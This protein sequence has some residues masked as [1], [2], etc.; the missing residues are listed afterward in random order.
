MNNILE[1]D[2][3]YKAV[4]SYDSEIELF[5]GEFIGLNGGA[6]FYAPDV[7]GLKKEG[8]ISIKVF[9]DE[10][11]ARNIEPKKKE[12]KFALRLEPALYAHVAAFARSKN[13]SINR[14]ITKSLEKQLAEEM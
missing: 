7:E 5:R 6:D 9:I 3:G 13:M 12:S 8:A 4:I 1:F 10:C 11:K 14:F 2:N